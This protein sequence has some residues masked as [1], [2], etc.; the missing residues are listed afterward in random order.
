MLTKPLEI[1]VYYVLP[2]MILTI[3][4]PGNI[5][6]VPSF[7][8]CLMFA[9]DTIFLVASVFVFFF[10]KNFNLSLYLISDLPCKLYSYVYGVSAFYSHL[11]LIYISIDKFISIKYYTKRLIK[12]KLNI[13]IFIC[14][15]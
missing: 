6:P 3:G 4:V 7:M 15:F 1:F 5:T 13:N 14:C 2:I 10:S 12:K 11:I 8:H 9:F